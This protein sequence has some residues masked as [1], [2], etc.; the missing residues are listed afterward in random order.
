MRQVLVLVL[1]CRLP[2]QVAAPHE[3]SGLSPQQYSRWLDQHSEAELMKSVASALEAAQPWLSQQ[4][5]QQ[6]QQ[7]PG[8][9]SGVTPGQRDVLQ[10]MKQLCQSH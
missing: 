1:L 4:Q 5:Q 3:R 2:A 9:G 8:E 10:V 7:S 6:Q